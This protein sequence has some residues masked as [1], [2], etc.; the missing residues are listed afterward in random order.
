MKNEDYIPKNTNDVAAVERLKHLPF[1]LVR[2]D[3]TV[4]LE[5]LQDG[6]WDVAEGIAEYLAPHVNEITQELLFVLNT[7]DG[8]WK[9]FII[10]GLIARS[11]NKLDPDLIK[12]LSRIAGHPSKIEA[13]D[14]VD[15]A[16]KDIIANKFL[17]G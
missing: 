1:E 14:T 9:Y 10:Y 7:N 17:C 3:V 12:A 4:L 16:A 13:E 11:K 6:H 8:M 2:Q 15:E 5:W